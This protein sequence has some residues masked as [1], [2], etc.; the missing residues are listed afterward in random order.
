MNCWRGRWKWWL[1]FTKF[2]VS[3][4]ICGCGQLAVKSLDALNFENRGEN[5]HE[6]RLM[7]FDLNVQ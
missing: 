2:E 6:L 7:Y 5:A 1:G 4:Q 3:I